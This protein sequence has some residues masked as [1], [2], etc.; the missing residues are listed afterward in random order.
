MSFVVV[1]TAN[2]AFKDVGSGDWF[3]TYVN[4]LVDG[5][6]V[7]SGDYFRPGDNLNRAEMAKLAV[8]AAGFTDADLASPA[9]ASF[10]DVPSTAWFYKYVETAKTHGFVSGNPDGTFKPTA[11]VDRASAAKI[12][13]N[14]MELAENTA[15]G[16][17][18]SDV[19]EAAWYYGVVET[20]YNNTV[21]DGYADGTFKP[22]AYVNRGEVAKMIVS[23]QNP[24]ARAEE[25]GEETPGGE[26]PGGE[27]PTGGDLT[28]AL[29]GASPA[30]TNIPDGSSYNVLA[31]FDFTA[32]A[33]T[34]IV[35]KGLTVTRGGYT[36]NT[37]VTGVSLWDSTG[38]RHGNII[39]S[40]TSEGKAV[41]SFPSAPITIKGG[42]TESVTLK[43]NLAATVDTGTIFFGVA[44]SGD[45]VSTAAT[46]AGTFP[47]NGATMGVVN[48][49]NSL[50]AYTVTTLS[51]G[52]GNSG[53]EVEL[54]VGQTQTELMKF[55]FQQSN[56]LEDL[57][58]TSMTVFVD[59]TVS[60]GD[61]IN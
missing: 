11:S 14:A 58:L 42:T 30:P 44:A 52:G 49:G 9:T 26:T 13:V 8:L 5:G 59:G 18:F 46:V 12:L 41:F 15:G 36:A 55:K 25:P 10:K 37:G 27:T 34:D 29:S 24:V 33:G 51:V 6:I 61:L 57:K 7:S 43:V 2:A 54:E 38:V 3:Y 40:L 31:V 16:P 45:I 19:A 1:S 39:Q 23:S 35:L 48:G 21:V 60:S 28:V 20:A 32:P 4:Q 53:S 56:S 17:H 50:A 22:G 47:L